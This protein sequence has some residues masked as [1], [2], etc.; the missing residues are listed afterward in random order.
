MLAEILPAR[1][2]EM[3]ACNTPLWHVPGRIA[4]FVSASTADVPEG[5]N[6][7]IHKLGVALR[8]KGHSLIV[9]TPRERTS[10]LCTEVDGIRYVTLK[11]FE[12]NPKSDAATA[13]QLVLAIGEV[14][15][16]FKPSVVIAESPSTSAAPVQMAARRLGLPFVYIIN[17]LADNCE[18]HLTLEQ[19]TIDA[20]EKVYLL[21]RSIKDQLE[22]NGVDATK[23]EVL[24]HHSCAD[25]L[26]EFVWSSTKSIRLGDLISLQERN[27]EG[28]SLPQ[29]K[30]RGVART[31]VLP[32]SSRISKIFTKVERPLLSEFNKILREAAELPE[33]DGVRFFNKF[34]LRIAV[35]AD[36]YMYNYY[37]DVCKS[38][39]YLTPENYKEILRGGIDLIIY[40]TCWRGVNNEEWKGVKYRDAPKAA[41]DEILSLA[42]SLGIRAVFQSIEDPSNFEYF[43][44]IAEKFDYILTTDVDCIEKYKSALGTDKVFFGE[45]GVNPK[46]NNPIGSRRG[47]R[48]AAFFAGSYPKRYKERCSDMEVIFD[49][50]L[51]SGGNLLVADR[52]YGTKSEEVSFPAR[53]VESILP[54]VEHQLLQ[55][56]HKLFRYNLNF[57]SIKDSPTM[58][59]MRVYELQAQGGG[60]ISNYAK[61]VFNKFPGIRIVPCKQDLTPDLEN[62]ETW[63]EYRL[64][65]EAVRNVFNGKTVFDNVEALLDNIG[66]PNRSHKKSETVCVICKKKTP[67]LEKA[68]L[69]QTYF[70][71]V[72]VQEGDILSPGSWG[73]L[74]EK[75]DI[76][77]FGWFDEAYDY[78][79]NYLNDMV[80]AFKYGNARYVTKLAYFDEMGAFVDGPQ[81]EYT[82]RCG[83][84][85]RSL[86][87]S[88]EFSFLELKRYQYREEIALARGYSLDPFCL[89]YNRFRERHRKAP[90][91]YALSVII[92]VFNNGN[93]LRSKCIPSIQRNVRWREFELILVD[94]GSTDGVTN[95]ILEELSSTY[96]NVVVKRN[97]DGGSG[98]ASRPRNQGIEI[99]TAPLV[100]FL[101]PDNEIC[102]RGYDN[103]LRLYTKANSG[104]EGA[105]DF[106]SG[107]HVKVDQ[108]VK[109]IGKHTDKEISVI[110]DLKA[111]YFKK[112]KFPVVATQSAVISIDFLRSTNLRFVEKSAGQDTLFGWELL[113]N[114]ARG[115]FTSEAYIVYYADRA[116]SVTND[117]D[118]KYFE[119]KL[120]LELSQIEFLK[121]HDLL[122]E[123][124][125]GHFEGFVNNWYLKK[126][127][128]VGSREY[129]RCVR[130]FDI[131]CGLYGRSASSFLECARMGQRI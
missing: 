89:N 106:V 40:T 110:G 99:A 6:G 97:Y 24:S 34:D 32:D 126:L 82:D 44:P 36:V 55:R 42:K 118:Y 76:G 11:A 2:P 25:H 119:K 121:K 75:H 46:L 5:E 71:K 69:H 94:D 12:R 123:Y 109:S 29:G 4:Y 20:A 21:S 81:H 120:I 84:K 115:A 114:S 93:Y 92:P 78:E 96:R 102:P 14:L 100:T 19:S 74:V 124:M 125:D 51:D 111:A 37:K 90:V 68:I 53:Y 70:S 13:D 49:S 127:A 117:V 47:I 88:D 130:L 9:F 22:V 3:M 73:E 79:E 101:D 131:I 62:N 10:A 65:S 30:A 17:A 18:A 112:G 98:S 103:L 108:A 113:C 67:A 33:S 129:E 77:Y 66:F 86:F 57:N 80:N 15:N 72:L 7:S 85:C 27:R 54:P 16:V 38:V 122:R 45:Y 104:S 8:K 91:N 50:I 26:S 87:S 52:N 48:N 31:N 41:L 59:A 43:L 1:Y 56:V 128:L 28:L 83:S 116:G 35:I 23:A 58:C 63:E 107:Y 61:S 64:N 95:Q 105:V 39:A 60:I